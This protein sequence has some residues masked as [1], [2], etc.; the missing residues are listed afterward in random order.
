MV[1][2]N[3]WMVDFKGKRHAFDM[4][5][6]YGV[7]AQAVGAD[8]SDPGGVIVGLRG[9]GLLCLRTENTGD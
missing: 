5:S 8:S 9:R 6:R 3:V 7:T 1:G 2:S 4:L